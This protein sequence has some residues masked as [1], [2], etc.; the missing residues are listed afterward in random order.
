MKEIKSIIIGFLL[1]T[2]IF[3]FIGMTKEE[4]DKKKKWLEEFPESGRYLPAIIRDKVCLVDSETGDFYTSKW[5]KGAE[6][7]NWI[8]DTNFSD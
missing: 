2:C 8:L 6:V 3:L 7:G 1:S 5:D 4:V